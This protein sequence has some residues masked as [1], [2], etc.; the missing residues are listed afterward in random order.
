[1]QSFTAALCAASATPIAWDVNGIAN[2][3]AQLGTIAVTAPANALYSSPTALPGNSVTVQ[4]IASAPGGASQSAAAVVTFTSGVSISIT[5]TVATLSVNERISVGAAVFND[6]DTGVTWLVNGVPNG[7]T[8]VGQIC[9]TGLVPCSGPP[10]P[11]PGTVDYLAP[12]APPASN[13]VMLTV[14]SHADPSRSATALLTITPATNS[15]AV[16][17]SPQYAFLAPTT[18][19][20]STLQFFVSVTGTANTAVSWSVQSGVSGAGCAGA[21]CGSISSAGLYSAPAIAPSPNAVSVTATSMADATKSATATVAVTSGPAIET[22]LPSSASAGAVQSFP[23]AVRGAGFTAGS[24]GASSVI[25]LNSVPRSTTCSSTTSCATV[26]NPSDVQASGSIT[27]QIENPGSPGALSNPVPF[28][29]EPFDPSAGVISLSASIPV[30]ASADIV[31]VE[32]T[33]AASSAPINVD[34]VGYLTGGN[35]CGIQG[36]PLAVVRPA[37]GASVASICVHGTALDPTFTYS[38]TGP[39]APSGNGDI[40]VTASAITGAL[41][42]MIELDLQI[43]SATLPGVRA[44]FI[45]TL[46]N[47][48]AVA[49]GVLEVK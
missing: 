40:A 9:V 15:V 29:I 28:V 48:R 38:F 46:N 25:L 17:L 1:M 12:A 3:N 39:G 22:I 26:L 36:S 11:S 37:S 6:S 31:V 44:L 13:P 10:S 19:A 20:P 49:T 41:P 2:G 45:T 16:T 35:T 32:P 43:S 42:N 33:N 47:D 18:G 4:A 23:L 24:G 34:F 5:P 7:N 14:V 21:A 30:A 27:V 8:T